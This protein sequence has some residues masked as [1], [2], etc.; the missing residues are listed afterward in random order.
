ME[1]SIVNSKKR[2]VP[3]FGVHK[4]CQNKLSGIYQIT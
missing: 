2:V 4:L 1:A 3:L